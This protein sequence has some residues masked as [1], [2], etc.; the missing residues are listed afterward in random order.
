MNA[1]LAAGL[2]TMA[3]LGAGCGGN[4]GRRQSNVVARSPAGGSALT[5][6]TTS[7]AD[8][9]PTTPRPCGATAIAGGPHSDVGVIYSDPTTAPPGQATTTPTTDPNPNC[10]PASTTSTT[11]AADNLAAGGEM[12]V[13]FTKAEVNGPTHRSLPLIGEARIKKLDPGGRRWSTSVTV[14]GGV[15]TMAHTFGIVTVSDVGGIGGVFLHT[16]CRF[17]TNAS[18]VGGCDGDLNLDDYHPQQRRIFDN[19]SLG[20][21]GPEGGYANGKF[22]GR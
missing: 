9:P 1:K 18:G 6:A 12:L 5:D 7:Q 8:T 22:P 17:T 11:S 14:S 20:W 16:I 4:P 21:A 2:V 19:V 10:R 13:R 15:P 3:L